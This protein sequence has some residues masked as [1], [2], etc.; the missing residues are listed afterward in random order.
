MKVIGLTGGT[1]SG[2]SVVS[3]LLA[4]MGAVIVDA[5]LVSRQI[6]LPGMPAYEEIKAYF[7]NDILQ[8]DGAIFRKK[9]GEIVFRDA[10]KL[11]FLNQCTHKYIVME[12]RKQMEEAKEAG[13]APLVV[14]DAPLLFEVGLEIFCDEVWVVY[15]DA[16]VRAE[17]VMARDGITYDTAMARIA[18]QKSWEEYKKRADVVIDNSGDLSA[19][20]AQLNQLM[21]KMGEAV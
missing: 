18:N 13:Q 20:S 3:R 7:G 12:M 19:L 21:E 1:G 5:D 9:L 4:E 10:Q 16:Q 2:K 15:A 8:E 17:R 6:V 11:A 14:L